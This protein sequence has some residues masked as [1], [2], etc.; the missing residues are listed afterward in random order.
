MEVAVHNQVSQILQRLTL[1]RGLTSTGSRGEP[2]LVRAHLDIQGPV[3]R[4]RW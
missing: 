3:P 1:P 4:R 2:G